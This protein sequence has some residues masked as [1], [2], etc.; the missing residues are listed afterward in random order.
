MARWDVTT[1]EYKEFDER[2][3]PPE[4]VIPAR[5]CAFI[6][7]GTHDDRDMKGAIYQR[8][9]LWIGYELAEL[10]SH[11]TPFY[12]SQ[13]LTLSM[14]TSSTLYKYVKALHGDVPLGEALDPDWVANK[15]CMLQVSHDVKVKKDKKRTYANIEGVMGCPRGV[16]TPQGSCIVWR[17]QDHRTVPLPNVAHLPPLWCDVVGKMLT[18][19]EWVNRS[20]EVAG[21]V[22]AQ[23]PTPYAA[24]SRMPSGNS[25]R[26]SQPERDVTPPRTQPVTQE[27]A[28]A[29]VEVPF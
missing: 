14:G 21:K 24:D 19:P 2:E 22:T 27:E 23:K 12:M 17:V 4:G 10:D 6:D 18:V 11:R 1:K 8:R 28:D 15:P 26:V 16:A 7:I 25:D 9:C 13:R 3:T 5:V 29:P 20:E